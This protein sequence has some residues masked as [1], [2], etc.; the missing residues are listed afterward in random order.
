MKA[1]VYGQKNMCNTLSASLKNEGIEMQKLGDDFYT[2]INLITEE[3]YDLAIVD[4]RSDNANQACRYIRE[5][6][7]IPLVLV[8]DSLEADWKW[9]KP[10]EADGYIPEVKQSGEL[11][12]RARALLRRLLLRNKPQVDIP[13]EQK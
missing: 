4:S 2:A 7:D 5:N 1:L 9:L 6:W 8:V 10:I 3:K 13:G 12:A 11:S